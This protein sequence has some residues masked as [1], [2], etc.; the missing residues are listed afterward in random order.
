MLLWGK[1]VLFSRPNV[2]GGLTTTM[3]MMTNWKF[4]KR[5]YV[6]LHFTWSCGNM[7][8]IFWVYELIQKIA[9][10]LHAYSQIVYPM[11]YTIKSAGPY[12]VFLLC[13]TRSTLTYNK[14]LTFLS[15][16]I[17]GRKWVLSSWAFALLMIGWEKTLEGEQRWC[18]TG[19]HWTAKYNLAS[20]SG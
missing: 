11:A 14:L 7:T 18:L 3:T 12:T 8:E 6:T 15:F 9:L 4:I 19:N 20:C 5:Q 16:S 10:I 17:R 1:F 2:G 13:S